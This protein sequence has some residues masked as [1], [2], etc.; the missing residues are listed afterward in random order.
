[1]G[2]EWKDREGER[3]V[4]KMGGREIIKDGSEEMGREQNKARGKGMGKGNEEGE[5]SRRGLKWE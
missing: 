2:T 4:W 1:M 3:G 5:E